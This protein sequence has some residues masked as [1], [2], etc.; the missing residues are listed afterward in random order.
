MFHVCLWN[1]VR[2]SHHHTLPPTPFP[3]LWYDFYSDLFSSSLGIWL[4]NFVTCF[5]FS[6]VKLALP[7]YREGF[8][9]LTYRKLCLKYHH[10]CNKPI[11]PEEFVWKAEIMSLIYMLF[12]LLVKSSGD[13]VSSLTLNCPAS[14]GLWHS[15]NLT[16]FKCIFVHLNFKWCPEDSVQQPGLW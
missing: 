11:N 12:L 16:L 4:F 9:H 3:K 7:E 15:P 5:S 8:W 13:E 10:R 1:G 6:F 2:C 14:V